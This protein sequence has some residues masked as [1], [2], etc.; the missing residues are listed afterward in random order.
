MV[1]AVVTINVVDVVVINYNF[2]EAIFS[3]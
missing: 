3:I 2:E 1:A